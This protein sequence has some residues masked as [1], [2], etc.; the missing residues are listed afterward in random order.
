M[1]LLGIAGLFPQ[2]LL[3]QAQVTLAS[4]GDVTSRESARS[5]VRV[6]QRVSAIRAVEG[7]VLFCLRS[8]CNV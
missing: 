5:H 6:D 4:L 1:N 8:S 2:R 3:L 7:P